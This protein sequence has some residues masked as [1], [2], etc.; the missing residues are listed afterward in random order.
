MVAGDCLAA[1]SVV[2]RWLWVGVKAGDVGG[3]FELLAEVVVFQG[4][5]LDVGD[6]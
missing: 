4:E 6:G 2:G 3:G 1:T 5:A